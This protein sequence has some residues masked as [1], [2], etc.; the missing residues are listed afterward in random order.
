MARLEAASVHA[1]RRLRAELVEHGAPQPLVRAAERA[2]RDELRHARMARAL[3]RRYGGTWCAPVVSDSPLRDVEAIATENAVE[4]CVRETFG[5]LI[6]T[7]QARAA[8]DPT[9]RAAMARIAR[10]ETRHAALAYAVDAWVRGKL[11]RAARTRVLAARRRATEALLAYD[12]EPAPDFRSALGLPTASETR[13]LAATM[14]AEL[15]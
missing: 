10:D 5:A 2:A 15:S 14:T 11:N 9:V 13:A 4:G 12:S 1:F 8:K 3:A 6:A 7:R